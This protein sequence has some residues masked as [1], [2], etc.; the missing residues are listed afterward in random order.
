M[1]VL[2]RFIEFIVFSNIWIAFLAAGLTL[3]T[4]LINKDL[5][6]NINV[7]ILVFFTTFSIY[8]LQRLIKHFF[9]KNNFSE[10]HTWI[11]N[12]I[13][14]IAVLVILSS[15]GSVYLFFSLFT[16]S[17]FIILL[18]FILISAFY[19]ISIFSNKRALRDL[20]FIKIF[21]IAITWAVITVILP[22]LQT[23]FI[24]SS[25]LVAQFFFTFLFIIA[26]TIPFDIRDIHL[27]DKKTRTLPQVLGTKD[28]TS[29]A[30]FI[31]GACL[32]L[33]YIYFFNITYPIIL[34]VCFILVRLSNKK[35]PE[36]F[37]SGILDGIMILFPLF[38]YLL[39][40]S[41]NKVLLYSILQVS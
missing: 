2:K 36:L 10:R 11:Y 41:K 19:A 23:D 20:P 25:S 34:F 12:N 15:I 26:I 14:F 5:S 3:N 18:P 17:D 38:N 35:M 28:A 21:L 13:K 29:L 22:F 4:Y 27:D 16:I 9:K 39:L 6:L 33:N 30:V 40:L 8:N 1:L 32:L 24:L 31:L 37:Y 7:C